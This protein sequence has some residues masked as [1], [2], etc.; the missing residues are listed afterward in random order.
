MIKFFIED[1][2]FKVPHPRK[3]KSWLQRIIKAEGFTLNQLNYIF[4]SDEYLLT[5]NRQYLDHDFY[6]DIITFDNSEEEGTIEGD[7]FISVDRVRDNAQ[8]FNKSF[9]EELHRVLAHGILHLVG[10]DDI[11]DDHELEMRNKEDF[12]LSNP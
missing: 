2:D 10:Y 9:E 1:V 3:T 7:L 11:D 5:V 4:C 8:E 6:T 12:Y